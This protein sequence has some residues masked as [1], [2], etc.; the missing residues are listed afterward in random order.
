MRWLKRIGEWI[1]RAESLHS[2][3]QSELVRAFI[4]PTVWAV[5]TGAA[6]WFGDVPLMW[7]LMAAALAFGG[8]ATALLRVS[9]YAERITP[10]NKL[11]ATGAHLALDL[12]PAEVPARLFAPNRSARRASQAIKPIAATP[13]GP[14]DL[15]PDVPRSIDKCQV[16]ITFVNN[17]TFP[18]SCILVDARTELGGF[19]PPRS[20]FPKPPSI[21]SPGQPFFITDE[22]IEMDEHPCG[23]LAG[24]VELVIKYGEPGKERY[25]MTVKGNLDVVI[26]QFGFIRQ[27]GISWGA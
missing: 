2:L 20:D 13:L 21:V 7:V 18:V 27:V 5:L 4:W 14:H 9:L 3:F 6:G 10:L 17:A 11:R 15:N 23:R 1:E 22:V 8:V 25:E 24:K 19:K 12:V 26:E 16:G